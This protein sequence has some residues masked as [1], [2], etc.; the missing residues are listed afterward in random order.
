[1]SALEAG[2]MEG[3]N[4]ILKTSSQINFP[5]DFL[6]TRICDVEEWQGGR[7]KCGNESKNKSYLLCLMHV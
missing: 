4:R 7:K 6:H 5:F 1:M 3:E 2:G